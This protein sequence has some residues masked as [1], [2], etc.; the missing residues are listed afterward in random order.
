[1]LDFSQFLMYSIWII[2]NMK[3]I[4]H[5]GL[6][7]LIKPYVETKEHTV[8]R[9]RDTGEFP[10]SMS[11][12]SEPRTLITT[13]RWT[14]LQLVQVWEDAIHPVLFASRVFPMTS[15]FSQ[16]Q[17]HWMGGCFIAFENCY[18]GSRMKKGSR[19][20]H[21]D[22]ERDLFKVCWFEG[23]LDLTKSRLWKRLRRDRVTDGVV[24]RVA[25]VRLGSASVDERAFHPAGGLSG[26]VG[27]Y[28]VEQKNQ[29]LPAFIWNPHA[30][31]DIREST[32]RVTKI[33]A[34]INKW[35]NKKECFKWTNKKKVKA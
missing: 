33:L 6:K 3:V 31:R 23:Q 8:L 15:P 4:I 18:V 7:K 29:F 28:V 9:S 5:S 30:H 26:T 27:A 24:E 17:H 12:D 16:H 10:G 11:L 13:R 20:N 21:P 25:A 19:R 32:H 22:I 35:S 34:K 1:M 2:Y 14:G